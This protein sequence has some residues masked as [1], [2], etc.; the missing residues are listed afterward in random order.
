[1]EVLCPTLNNFFC[2]FCDEV[3][4]LEAEKSTQKKSIGFAILQLLEMNKLCH[5]FSV[6]N[7]HTKLTEDHYI[8]LYHYQIYICWS[9]E[10]SQGK[11]ER[12][13]HDNLH[14]QIYQQKWCHIYCKRVRAG[15][16]GW[17]GGE[18]RGGG[19]GEFHISKNYSECLHLVDK[20]NWATLS[21]ETKHGHVCLFKGSPAGESIRRGWLKMTSCQHS[22]TQVFRMTKDSQSHPS[23][24]FFFSHFYGL[25]PTDILPEMSTRTASVPYQGDGAVC[26]APSTTIKST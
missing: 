21:K 25:V 22:F 13:L 23:L 24:I 20:N 12:L 3:N 14:L 4:T 11:V 1:M 5:L 7:K 9:C 18:D 17:G 19:T 2:L 6:K 8:S 10:F 15:G 26:L 16:G